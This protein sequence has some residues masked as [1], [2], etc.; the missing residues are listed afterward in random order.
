MWGSLL[1]IGAS[2]RIHGIASPTLGLAAAESGWAAW[3]VAAGADPEGLGLR[4]SSPLLLSLQYLLFFVGA[5]GEAAVRLPVVLAGALTPLAAWAWRGALGPAVAVLLAGWL[6]VDPAL[7]TA[8]QRGDAA[9][10]AIAIALWLGGLLVSQAAPARVAAVFGLLATC[11][12]LGW[13]LLPPL[14]LAARRRLATPG[15]LALA[16]GVAL[17]ACTAGLLQ[18]AGLAALS[19]SLSELAGRLQLGFPTAVQC[20]IALGLGALGW[21]AARRQVRAPWQVAAAMVALVLA[22]AA[23]L[24]GAR[25]TTEPAASL[26]RLVDDL[27]ELR[28]L[29]SAGAASRLEIVSEPGPDPRIGWHLRAEIGVRW[30]LAPSDGADAVITPWPA[31]APPGGPWARSLYATAEPPQVW[32]LWLATS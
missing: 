11:G 21:V 26:P 29:G 13:V 30:V 20:S 25:R 8:A 16:A 3:L 12:P 4:P 1:V 7:V 19:F 23:A 14:A 6:A 17:A 15:A 27:D 22:A 9:V 31:G 10:L 28:T 32:A 2:L 24:P 5:D 18:R